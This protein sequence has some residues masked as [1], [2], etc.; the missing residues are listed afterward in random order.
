MAFIRTVIAIRK[1]A[2]D[3]RLY[4]KIVMER[5]EAL[6]FRMI[7]STTNITILLY[8]WV[9]TIRS[10]MASLFTPSTIIQPIT[11][12]SYMFGRTTSL[13]N[14]TAVKSMTGGMTNSTVRY[15]GICFRNVL[16]L[17]ASLRCCSTCKI[18]L[19]KQ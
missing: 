14:T 11:I 6:L 18:S 19:R 3:W 16:V 10:K 9:F 4:T 8:R 15:S 12:S 2:L 1:D 17:V 7:I 13:T 5:S